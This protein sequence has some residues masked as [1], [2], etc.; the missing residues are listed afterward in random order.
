MSPKPVRVYSLSTCFHCKDLRKMLEK[1]AVP[2]EY[3]AVDVLDEEAREAALAELKK[4]GGDR[5][6]FPTTVVGDTVVVGARRPEILE[7]LETQGIMKLSFL[8]RV[9]AKISGDR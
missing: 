7:A 5:P 6:V 2:F 3:L 8:E 1:Y 4:L 9:M